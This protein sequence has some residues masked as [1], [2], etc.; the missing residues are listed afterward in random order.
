MCYLPGHDQLDAINHY[1]STL[2]RDNVT[3]LGQAL[4]LR[5]TTLRDLPHG[6]FLNE[7]M[8]LW[9]DEAEDVLKK[10]NPSWRSLVQGLRNK[11]VQQNG[12]ANRIA[13]DHRM[14]G[15]FALLQYIHTLQFLIFCNSVSMTVEF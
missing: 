14:Q 15:M 13:A 6:E 11:I 7:V 2:G 5:Y 1:L 3:K 12:I 9:L 4:G 8:T 10:G